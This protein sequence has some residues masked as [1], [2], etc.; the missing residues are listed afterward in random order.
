M[1]AARTK[2]RDFEIMRTV[3]ALAEERGAIALS[4]AAEEVGIG[5]D[6]LRALLEPILFL[7]F[8]GAGGDIVG[9]ERAFL[10]TEDGML[11]VA[12]EH[13]LRDLCA[14]PPLPDVALRLLVAGL[15]MQALASKP[16]PDLDRAVA[17]LR[18]VVAA[19][20]A[21]DVESPPCLGVAQEA[22]RRGR[23]LRFR[24]LSDAASTPTDREVLPYRVFSKW[25]HWYC[26][27]R[28]VDGDTPKHF[29]IDR[30]LTAEVGAI[31]F[32]P[33]HDVDIP[34]WFDMG[35]LRRTV[36]VRLRRSSLAS[37]PRPLGI[38][39]LADLGDGRVDVN[40]T[41][42]GDR[43]LEHLLVCLE[44]DAEIVEP[45]RYRELQRHAAM[46]LETT[47]APASARQPQGNG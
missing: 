14:D 3:L 17:K 5:V 29:R 20:L 10:L 38:K 47:A 45:A 41:V 40:L 24:Y 13:W 33:P 23:S 26:F 43:R 28:E 21:I 37:L 2:Q 32:D 1:A 27:G 34:D 4:D 39:E 42:T 46:G 22:Y 25:G 7:E 16:S 8:R 18:D 44:P 30:M 31:P 35:A 12:E 11:Q 6:E 36:R 9:K 19:G 15:T